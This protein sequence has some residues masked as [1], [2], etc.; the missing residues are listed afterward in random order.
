MH[1]R[2]ESGWSVEEGGLVYSA[3]VPANTTAIPYLPA[4]GVE[5]ITE[6]G[7]PVEKS[8]GVQFLKYEYGMA[9]FELQSGSYRFVVKKFLSRNR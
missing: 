1:G 3:I 6:G 9:F 8:K 7:K 2:I 4:S 5:G